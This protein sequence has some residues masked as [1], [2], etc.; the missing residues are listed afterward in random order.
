MSNPRPS[1]SG[2]QRRRRP[3]ASGQTGAIPVAMPTQPTVAMIYQVADDARDA[4][5]ARRMGELA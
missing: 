4:E 5:V 2:F 3:R 1:G